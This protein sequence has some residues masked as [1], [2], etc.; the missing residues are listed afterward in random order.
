MGKTIFVSLL[1]SVLLTACANTVDEPSGPTSTS[2]GTGGGGGGG[3]SS[4][5]GFA[6]FSDPLAWCA[7]RGS[8]EVVCWQPVLGVSEAQPSGTLTTVPGI[9]DATAVT[10]QFYAACAHRASGK[11]ACWGTNEAGE[12]LSLTPNGEAFT[13]ATALPGIDAV[14]VSSAIH[15]TCVIRKGGQVACFGVGTPAAVDV[16]GL[17]DAI[18]VAG[19][20]SGCA[21]RASGQVWCWQGVGAA[22]EAVPF[23]DDATQLSLSDVGGCALHASGEV[24][25]WHTK[26]LS[27]AQKIP[28]FSNVTRVKAGGTEVCAIDHAGDVSCWPWWEPSAMPADIHDARDIGLDYSQ[29]C[30]IHTSGELECGGVSGS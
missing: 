8:G 20:A 7:V 26:E 16:P 25:C 9:D 3:P 5:E 4:P 18:A 30:V 19:G 13:T 1:G 21:L 12:L 28:G 17:T 6:R 11:I 29:R 10:V 27:S 22:P 24:S 23:I 15:S 14:A 2:V